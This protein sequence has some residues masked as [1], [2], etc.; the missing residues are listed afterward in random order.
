[1]RTSSAASWPAS[2]NTGRRP[3]SHPEPDHDIVR[4]DFASTIPSRVACLKA[5]GDLVVLI[6]GER[7]GWSETQS[8]ISPTHESSGRVQREKSFR[9]CSP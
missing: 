7:Y 1:M 6:L 4:E 3:R 8:G 2:R 9:S 5:C